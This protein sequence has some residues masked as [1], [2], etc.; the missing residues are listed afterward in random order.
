[1]V[2][3]SFRLVK[4]NQRKFFKFKRTFL[5]TILRVFLSLVNN[6]SLQHNFKTNISLVDYRLDIDETNIEFVLLILRNSML[7]NYSQLVELTATDNLTRSLNLTSKRFLVSYVL[8]N[9]TTT[10]RLFLNVNC[11]LGLNTSSFIYPNGDW[12]EREIYDL[13]GIDFYGHKNL[14]RILND[15]GFQGYPL[16]K[17]FPLTGFVEINY[18]EIAKGVRYNPI[19]FL[20]ESKNFVFDSCLEQDFGLEKDLLFFNNLEYNNE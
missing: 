12:L 8:S 1:M 2:K 10:S 17:N 19:I 6:I 7:F 20:Q 14:I 16:R 9:I 13:F 11:T 18:D 5:V 3:R 4:L 15:Y